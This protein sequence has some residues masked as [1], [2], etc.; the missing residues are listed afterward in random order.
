MNPRPTSQPSESD[1]R[2]LPLTVIALLGWTAA[3]V[4]YV[5]VMPPA[6]ARQG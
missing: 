5:T 4:G 6:R 3:Q 2:R 1:S